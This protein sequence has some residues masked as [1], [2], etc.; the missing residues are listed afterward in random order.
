M[1]KHPLFISFGLL[2]MVTGCLM[3]K[4]PENVPLEEGAK[5]NIKEEDSLENKDFDPNDHPEAE[6]TVAPGKIQMETHPQN[7][8]DKFS[9]YMEVEEAEP[10]AISTNTNSGRSVAAKRKAAPSPMASPS[11]RSGLSGSFGYADSEMPSGNDEA[12]DGHLMSDI[13]AQSGL[14]NSESYTDYGVNSF[15]QSSEDSLST[16]SID[17]DTASYTISRRKIRDGS[18]PPMAGVRAEEFI[19]YFNYDYPTADAQPFD[20][21]VDGMDDPFRDGH[22]I[23]RVGVQGKELT[24]KNR[25]PLHLT[26]LIDVSGS[27]SSADKLPMAQ[28]A[29][30]LLI[31]TLQEGDTVALATYAGRVARIL[32]PTSGTN[33]QAIHAAI[34][35]LSSGGSTAMSSGIDIAYDMAWNAFQSGAE[36]R[37]M[38]MSD[39]DANVGNTGWNTMLS[40]IQGYADRGVTLSTIGLGMGNYKDTTMEQLANNGDGNNYYIDS[41]EEAKK[42]FVDGF[43]GTMIS[44]ARDVKIQVEMN[45]DRVSSY[46]LIGY[47]N[48]DIADKDFRNDRV[49]A[50]EVGAGHSVTA[51]Y[52]VIL[53]EDAFINR[54]PSDLLTVRLRY[55]QPGADKSATERAWVYSYNELSGTAASDSLQ[56]A[57]VAGTFAEIL[58]RSPYASNI[59]LPSLANYMNTSIPNKQE[60]DVELLSLIKKAGKLQVGSTAVLR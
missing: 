17:V 53:S 21:H 49:D 56:R 44:I 13:S 1:S 34:D 18:L 6:V 3:H 48:R 54:G 20:V 60:E 38:I 37:V 14:V 27:M 28:D 19:N 39:G 47:E 42:L 11:P 26:F 29:M 45:P 15:T 46:R 2:S 51:L 24:A 25:P 8:Q 59:S 12:V 43:N 40:Q 30:H 4:L 50:G 32:E 55:E 7:E 35:S 31:D 57:Y 10:G 41:N 5:V 52:E 16:F 36:N 23:V 58:R 9:D 22:H 33:K